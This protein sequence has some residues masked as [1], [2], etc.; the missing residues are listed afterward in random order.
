[1]IFIYVFLQCLFAIIAA[2]S[3]GFA[4]PLISAPLV[5]ARSSQTIARNYNTFTAPIVSAVPAVSAPL[6]YS[7]YSA[8]NPYVQPAVAAPIVAASPYAAYN[9]YAAPIIY[10]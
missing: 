6:A 2:A 10:K 4:A 5:T 7:A 3:A 1:M 8:Y 9:P